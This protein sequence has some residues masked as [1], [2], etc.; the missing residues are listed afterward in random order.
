MKHN[1]DLRIAAEFS[2]VLREAFK[3]LKESDLSSRERITM[4][5]VEHNF[6][7]WDKFERTRT[8][9]WKGVRFRPKLGDQ[10]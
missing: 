2:G 1:N 5:E 3:A 7:E 9:E 10:P 8:G 4:F 6:C